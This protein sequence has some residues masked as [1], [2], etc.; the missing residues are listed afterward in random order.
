MTVLHEIL[1][2]CSSG[3]VSSF[4]LLCKAQ[5]CGWLGKVGVLWNG[6]HQSQSLDDVNSGEGEILG[7]IDATPPFLWCCNCFFL[8]IVV[9]E[10]PM[11]GHSYRMQVSQFWNEWINVDFFSPILMSQLPLN[12]RTQ[13]CHY[14]GVW[15]LQMLIS[16]DKVIF[17]L[18]LVLSLT[19]Y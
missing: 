18:S 15:H 5:S 6:S 3:S 8:E 2:D 10:I 4:R 7:R 14:F 11:L 13:L 17:Q 12:V 19:L 16:K 9:N 1:I